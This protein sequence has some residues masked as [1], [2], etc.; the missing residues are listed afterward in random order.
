MFR[1][2]SGI[3]LWGAVFPVGISVSITTLYSSH[4]D[5]HISYH[6]TLVA[7]GV[8]MALIVSSFLIIAAKE[9]SQPHYFWLSCGLLGMGIFDLFHSMF[10]EGNLFVWFHSSRLFLGGLLF[11]FVCFRKLPNKI[12]NPIR[13]LIL[14]GL[15]CFA[16]CAFSF[17]FSD[18]L[19]LMILQGDFS[20]SAT[21]LN[22]TGGFGFIISAIFFTIRSQQNNSREDYFLALQSGI[23][24]SAG[25]LYEFSSLWD[26]IWW[27]VHLLRFLAYS[28]GLYV[29]LTGFSKLQEVFQNLSGELN[30][31]RKVLLEKQ[32]QLNSIVNNASSV[33][34]LKDIEGRYILIN[35]QF[36]KIF[37]LTCEEI[38][39]KT[40]LDI[41][42]KDFA[43]K[44]RENDIQVLKTNTLFELEEQAPLE[45]GVHDYISIKF[46]VKGSDGKIYGLGGISTDITY[47]R[48]AEKELKRY[49]NQLEKTN[50]ILERSNKDLEDFA[51]IVSHDL[52][53]P[54]RKII[55]RP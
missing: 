15:G 34:Y 4:Q 38:K 44:F 17:I 50:N 31:S 6:A 28:I 35:K 45:D 13:S 37:N 26:P 7:L 46:P 40:D 3:I 18:S 39:G 9:K 23:F 19:P 36:E 21:F 10:E 2:Y 20:P 12:L 43:E 29:I 25:L 27:Y 51:Y 16:F 48:K 1:H 11:S 42:E 54:L 41:F 14:F 5:I 33:I 47:R 22:I 55:S 8:A 53:S 49:S 30:D 32:E 52:K 24:A